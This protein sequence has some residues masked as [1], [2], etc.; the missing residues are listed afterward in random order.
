MIN[1]L[2][3]GLV[4]IVIF[5]GVGAFTYSYFSQ[6]KSVQSTTIIWRLSVWFLVGAGLTTL[7]QTILSLPGIPLSISLLLAGCVALLGLFRQRKM[8]VWGKES[9]ERLTLSSIS[10][11]SIVVLLCGL[12][13][14][15][16][17]SRVTYTWD[18]IAFWTP[19]MVGLFAE[20]KVT[21]HAL[22][23]FNHPEYPLML[24][25]SGADAMLVTG[26]PSDIAAK[27]VLFG[28]TLAFFG[29]FGSFLRKNTNEWLSIFWLLL[30]GTGFIFREHVAGEYVGTADIFVGI[31]MMAGSIMLLSKRPRIAL[32][33]LLFLPWAK[34]EGLIFTLAT[35]GMMFILYPSLRKH[36]LFL[37]VVFLAP[38]RFFVQYMQVDSSQYFKFSELYA[39]PWMEYATY[40]VHAFREEFRNLSKWNLMF[41]FFLAESAV[42]VQKILKNRELLIIYAALAAQLVAYLVIFTITP[43][44]Q[45]SFI[46]TA[47]SR[48]T[49][50]LAPTIVVMASYLHGQNSKNV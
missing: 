24:P 13:F 1:D 27:V 19:K 23:P 2:F 33:M 11:W 15:R 35:C 41:F 18:S 10:F 28:Y 12:F 45:A 16:S 42:A 48:L 4:V 20:N 50:H 36:I 17:L 47:I 5:I 46:A 44:E 40:S 7:A 37:S 22:I 9:K 30:L 38:W 29:L 32:V 25:I 21:K 31:Y 39:R 3:A 26:L 8:L 6:I 14:F 43:E 49:L 34:S